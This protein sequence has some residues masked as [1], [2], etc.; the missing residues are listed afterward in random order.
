MAACYAPHFRDLSDHE[1]HCIV[2]QNKIIHRNFRLTSVTCKFRLFDP[3][4]F[5]TLMRSLMP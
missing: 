5:A 4:R 1:D 2:F 3:I